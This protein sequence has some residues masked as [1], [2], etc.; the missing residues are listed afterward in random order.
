MLGNIVSPCGFKWTLKHWTFEPGVAN[1]VTC[2]H[3][4][5]EISAKT[6]CP[7]AMLT[8]PWFHMQFDVL[9]KADYL[10]RL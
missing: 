7:V 6:E 8:C 5:V 9:T 1:T 4:S 10:A 2:F 3:M